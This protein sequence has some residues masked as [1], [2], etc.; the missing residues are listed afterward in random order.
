[1]QFEGN[2]PQLDDHGV[3]QLYLVDYLAHVPCGELPRC[4]PPLHE[5]HLEAM[6]HQ[7][8][9]SYATM[10][11]TSGEFHPDFTPEIRRDMV[12]YIHAVMPFT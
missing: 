6:L 9:R 11:V 2:I 12:Q 4:C 10:H 3:P 7:E 1:M 8:Q 5:L